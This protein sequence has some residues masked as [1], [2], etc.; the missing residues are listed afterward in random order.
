MTPH[1]VTFVP[2]MHP[3]WSGSF[4][5]RGDQPAALRSPYPTSLARSTCYL[6]CINKFTRQI[7]KNLSSATAECSAPA[8]FRSPINASLR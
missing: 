7:S 4:D 6:F 2:G 1:T 8:S 5:W 3:H